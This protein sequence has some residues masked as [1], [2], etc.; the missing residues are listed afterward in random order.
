MITSPWYNNPVENTAFNAYAF[1]QSEVEE[2]ISLI[3]QGA[4]S[5]ACSTDMDESD[6]RYI[7]NEV[8]RRYGMNISL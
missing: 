5:I 4:T 8:A 7:E 1:H 3:G 2:V 6:K